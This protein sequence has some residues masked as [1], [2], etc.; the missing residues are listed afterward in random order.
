MAERFG[1]GPVPRPPHWGGF[2]VS[3]DRLEF[4]FGNP[5]RLHDRVVY[6]AQDGGGFSVQRLCP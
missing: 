1:D 3:L 2:R 4:W 6:T 5:Y